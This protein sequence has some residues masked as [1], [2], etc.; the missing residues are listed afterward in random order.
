[1]I[2]RRCLG[3]I[4]I[5]GL[6]LSLS[7]QSG[8]LTIRATRIERGPVLDGSLADEVWGQAVPVNG[9]KMVFPNAG[10][11]PSERTE[12]RILFDGSDLYLGVHCYDRE[13]GK[14]TANTMAHDT[15]EDYD[16]ANDD[17][18]KILL[19]PFQDKRDAYL[20]IVNPRGARSEG[21]AFGEHASLNWDGIWEAKSR[22]LPD[23]WST[24]IRIPFKS[25][26]FN[27]GIAAWGINVE[28]NISRKQETIRLSGIRR[29]AFFNNAAEA[30]L[31]E[32]IAGVKQ[33]LGLTFRPYG[34]VSAVREFEPGEGAEWKVDGGFDLYKN[35]T[36]NF[37]GAFSYNTD[38]AETE[39]DE[40]RL[41]LTRFSLY[42]PE[43]RTFFLEGSE[44]FNFAGSS[45]G[46]DSV[47]VPFFSRRIGLLAGQ[48][49]PVAFGTKVYGKLGE[50][51]IALID[52]G[53]RSFTLK[54]GTP[55]GGRNF[56]AG[57]IYQ[58]L[59]EE[60][61]VGIIFTHGS[62]EGSNNT[63][64]GFDFTFKTSRFLKN[65]NFN[66]TAWYVHS[67]NAIKNGRHQGFGFR[68]DYPNDL[69]D[70]VTSYGYYGDAL[71]PG[72][73]FLPRP[74]VQNY[75]LGISYKP[76]PEGGF[77]GN[78]VRQFFFELRFT[79]YWDLEGRLETLRIFTA[80]LN[81]QTESGEHIEFNVIPNRDVLPYD[82]EIADGVILP[83]GAY[84]FTNYALQFDTAGHRPWGAHA[85][86]SFGPFYSGR[87]T[88]AEIGFSLKFKGFATFSLNT[89][90]V[91]GNLPQGKFSENVYELKADLFLSPDL[92]LMNYI[93]YDDVSKNLGFNLRFRWQISP[94]NE[95]Y[96]V[97]T[98]NWERR[99]DP[100]SRF[101]PLGERGVFKITLSLRP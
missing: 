91:R 29:D 64:A 61:K 38:F 40:R 19:D 93:Q 58:N 30:A 87:Y 76:R 74:G 94:G 62:P 101:I 69:W 43:K 71:D 90:F 21:L 31:L 68:L 80:P 81:I 4:M 57:R 27:P 45:G 92:G 48:R 16:E 73:G 11:E 15:A 23:G 46:S 49:A 3:W 65:Q 25:I 2:F 26:S 97:Y 50:T 52:V 22:I 17:T 47:F 82:F 84:D 34:L 95:I 7:G 89:N 13:P 18:I 14:I 66:A 56:V 8:P 79:S 55:V 36:P 39:A 78:L 99:W 98:K 51:S 59:W 20:F 10:Q 60:S 86:V 1:M 85:E 12:L 37:V 9:F 54:D 75:N 42:F 88:N 41:N 77:V 35:I 6:A 5:L 24:E 33:G 96:F 100:A 83:R 53:T 32:G 72:L 70:I 67:W 28:R 44:I 63:L